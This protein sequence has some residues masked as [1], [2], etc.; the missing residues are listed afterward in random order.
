MFRYFFL[1]TAVQQRKYL[2]R[3]ISKL[4]YICTIKLIPVY[5]YTCMHK[6]LHTYT[7]T[8]LYGCMHVEKNINLHEDAHTD[9]KVKV[10]LH[11]TPRKW[12]R[13]P[14]R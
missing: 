8:S 7:R 11:C 4:S 14:C 12:D 5:T 1:M 10:C 9:N 2:N 6:Y 3:N 13:V